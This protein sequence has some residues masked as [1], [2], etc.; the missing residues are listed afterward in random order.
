MAVSTVNAGLELV[1]HRL[2][3]KTVSKLRR[4]DQCYQVMRHT[5]WVYPRDKLRDVGG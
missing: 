2:H 5:K 4:L 1:R 3:R